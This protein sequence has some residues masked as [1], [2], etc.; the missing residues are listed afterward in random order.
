MVAPPLLGDTQLTLGFAESCLE[1]Q[2]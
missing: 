1:P 2:L